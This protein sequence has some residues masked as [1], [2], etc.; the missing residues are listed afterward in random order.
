[1]YYEKRDSSVDGFFKNF[2]QEK[3][4]KNGVV[5]VEGWDINEV[6]LMRM[7]VVYFNVVYYFI[8]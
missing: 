2:C 7:V 1:M 4:Y 3:E 8:L 5:F 6:I